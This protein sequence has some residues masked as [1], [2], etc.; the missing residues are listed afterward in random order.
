M[1][2][3]LGTLLLTSLICLPVYADN[4]G[5]LKNIQT[6]AV[7]CDKNHDG[8]YNGHDWTRLNYSQ[9][10]GSVAMAYLVLEK[11]SAL[12]VNRISQRRLTNLIDSMI[13]MMDSYY[14]TAS[15]NNGIYVSFVLLNTYLLGLDN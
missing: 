9:K 8:K 12:N 3:L 15:K 14:T 4:R 7:N 6:G 11:E 13:E 2:K 5:Y 10:R 1:K